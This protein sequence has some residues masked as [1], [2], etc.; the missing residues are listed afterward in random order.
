[1]KYEE[2]SCN[3]LRRLLNQIDDELKDANLTGEKRTELFY[4]H[5]VINGVLRHKI[6]KIL[7]E[8]DENA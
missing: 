3:Q 7:D 2:M 4:E 5:M 1:M 8:C 6:A